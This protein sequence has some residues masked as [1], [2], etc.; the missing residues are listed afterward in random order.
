MKQEY[1]QGIIDFIKMQ[2]NKIHLTLTFREGTT[3]RQAEVTLKRLLWEVM[4]RLKRRFY[5]KKQFLTGIVSKELQSNGTVHFHAI[6]ADPHGLVQSRQQFEDLVRFRLSKYPV[7]QFS[8][9]TV[10][11]IHKGFS[12]QEYYDKGDCALA[13][14]ITKLFENW[15]I[16]FDAAQNSIGIIGEGDIAFGGSIG[17]L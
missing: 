13:K 6:I 11:D 16:S 5:K 9:K 2:P 1:R 4:G 7:S 10:T 8:S 14:Y 12:V 17:R 3:E 15:S